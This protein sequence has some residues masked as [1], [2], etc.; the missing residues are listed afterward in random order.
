MLADEPNITKSSTASE[1]PMRVTPY[2]DSELPKRTKERSEIV[3]PSNAKSK[4]LRL[5]PRRTM[6]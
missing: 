3:L 6:P 5:D 1:L 4:T 2:T